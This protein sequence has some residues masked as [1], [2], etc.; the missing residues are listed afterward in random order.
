MWKKIIYFSVAVIFGIIF[1][2]IT[3]SAN[4]SDYKLTLVDT[5]IHN[6]EYHIVPQIFL[7]VPFDTKSIVEDNSETAE[8]EIYPAAGMVN[9]T[10]TEGE[11]T[12]NY[13]RYEK[14]YLFFVFEINFPLASY[15]DSGNN[16]VNKSA[17]EFYNGD[18]KYTFNFVQNATYNTSEYKETPTNEKEY[19]LMNS[20][21]LTTIS[22]DWKFIPVSLSE[23]TIKYIKESIGGDITNIKI[24]DCRGEVQLSENV[25]FDFEEEF[26]THQYIVDI[27]KNVNEK[28]DA[29]YKATEKDEIKSLTNEINDLL[30]NFKENFHE[31]TKDTSYAMTLSEK[32]LT[33]N[34][35]YWKSIAYLGLFFVLV[36]ILYAMLFHFRAITG[37]I[38]SLAN[39]N[40]KQNKG[41]KKVQPYIVKK[42]PV[43]PKALEDTVELSE[44]TNEEAIA[45]NAEQE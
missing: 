1:Y 11:K 42:D 32:E 25:S 17:I 24:I 33:P 34:A 43:K 10:Y 3:Y 41:G 31:N 22:D 28:L 40:N 44:K 45:D 13:S 12:V 38:K 36:M 15:V 19:A 29:Y 27:N 21:D 35:V 26:F 2:L 37:F 18:N 14:A 5:A 7:E 20:R 9:Y 6:K 30:I 4:L 16:N 8:L 39:R 23:T